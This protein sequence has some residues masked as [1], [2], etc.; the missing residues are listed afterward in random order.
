MPCERR[1]ALRQQQA[2]YPRLWDVGSPTRHHHRPLITD[3]PLRSSTVHPKTAGRPRYHAQH[4]HSGR[5]EAGDR[6]TNFRRA[7]QSLRQH[8][9]PLLVAALRRSSREIVDGL[10]PSAAAIC[11]T[12]LPRARSTAISSRSAVRNR[13]DGGPHEYGDIPPAS[14]NHLVPATARHRPRQHIPSADYLRRS[15]PRTHAPPLVG[16]LD[17]PV[18]ASEHDL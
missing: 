10:R 13:P 11:R 7:S 5:N 12:P 1:I 15:C 16:A 3:N 2:T 6:W 8:T 4:A 18:T 17:G 9:Y 14:R